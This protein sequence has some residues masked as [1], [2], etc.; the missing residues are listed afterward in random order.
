MVQQRAGYYASVKVVSTRTS[1]PEQGNN[2]GLKNL[3]LGDGVNQIMVTGNE[4]YGIQPSWN[5]RRLPGTTVEQDTR[6]LTPPGSFGA[7]KGTTSYAGGVSDG[8]YGATAFNYNRFDVAAKKGW[9]FFDNEEVALGSAINAPNATSEVD[10]TLNQ[11][12]LTST[13]SY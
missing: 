4:Y 3:Y 6:S 5:W 11:C 12:L 1:Q 13:V 10:T 7:T 2:Q 9:F 8:T